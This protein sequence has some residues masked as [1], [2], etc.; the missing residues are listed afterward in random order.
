MGHEGSFKKLWD[1]TLKAISEGFKL[2]F[3]PW[4]WPAHFRS[5]K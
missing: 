1:E 3:M 2:F 5:L 4:K